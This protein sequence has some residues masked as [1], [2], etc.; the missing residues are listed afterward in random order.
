MTMSV[1]E[2]AVT[3]RVVEPC[4]LPSAAWMV[5]EPAPTDVAK[6]FEPAALLMVA[7]LVVAEVQVTLL[8]MSW[9]LASL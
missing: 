9:V 1:A 4:T 7:T 8:V 3:V 2:L 5:L 6:P